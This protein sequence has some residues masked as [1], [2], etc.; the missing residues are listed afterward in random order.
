K[1]KEVIY[2]L[3]SLLTIIG[4]SMPWI[5]TIG[6][7]KPIHYLLTKLYKFISYNRKVIISKPIGDNAV[8]CIPDFN[9]TY[10]WLYIV[11][12]T[13]VSTLV[14]QA[15]S[16]LLPNIVSPN[17]Y[18]LEFLMCG[19]QIV[20]QGLILLL[21]VKDKM[22]GYIGN[23]ITVSLI[24]SLLLIP[25]LLA[26][27]IAVPGTIFLISYFLLVVGFMILQHQERVRNLQLPTYLTLTWILY[28]LI[29]IP[30]LIL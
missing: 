16:K 4:H 23:M 21:F 27:I 3:D 9:Q 5:K 7:S 14:L 11:F 24:G 13:V 29:W 22:L 19:G 12:A 2:G 15:Y 8:S 6:Q 1:T 25:I 10:R 18:L 28:R 20:F 17:N 30:I 26:S